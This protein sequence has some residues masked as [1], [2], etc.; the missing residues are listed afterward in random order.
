MSKL[1]DLLLFDQQLTEE[2]LAIQKTVRDYCDK[3]LMPRIQKANREEL[4][5][6]EIY[7]ELADLGLLGPHIK[8]YGCAGVSNVSYGLIAREIERVDSSYRSAFSVQSSLAM[9]CWYEISCKKSRWRIRINW[10]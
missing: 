10:I 3:S 2:E 4:F 6:K 9:S 5:D 7:K 1:P 8:G